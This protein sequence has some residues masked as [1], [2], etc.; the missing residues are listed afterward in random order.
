MACRVQDRRRSN[1]RRTPRRNALEI[2][3]QGKG[4]LGVLVAMLLPTGL[5]VVKIIA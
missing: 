5:A 3:A 1:G 4:C 2:L